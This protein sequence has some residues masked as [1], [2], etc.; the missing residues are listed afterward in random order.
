MAT[1]IIEI[2]KAKSVS[3]DQDVRLYFK[4]DE[5]AEPDRPFL[6]TVTLMHYEVRYWDYPDIISAVKAF[7]QLTTQA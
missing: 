1:G 2:A 5:L 3:L 7:E 4:V 6:I